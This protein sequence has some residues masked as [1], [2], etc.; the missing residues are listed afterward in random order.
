MSGL[1]QNT[2]FLTRK[3]VIN[4]LANNGVLQGSSYSK[5]V[6]LGKPVE[7]CMTALKERLNI[8]NNMDAAK[9]V[10]DA[11]NKEYSEAYKDVSDF[12]EN[13]AKPQVK[14]IAKKYKHD[15]MAADFYMLNSKKIAKNFSFK[16]K[17]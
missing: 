7:Y 16:I 6:K 3:Q 5:A 13:I 12:F 10:K 17:Y 4:L 15:F 14:K 11:E 9:L 2:K 1:S 8:L